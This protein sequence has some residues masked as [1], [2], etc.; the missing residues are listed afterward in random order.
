MEPDSSP[1]STQNQHVTQQY[2]T[3][4]QMHVDQNEIIIIDAETDDSFICP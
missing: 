1:D 2:I 4:P 3:P